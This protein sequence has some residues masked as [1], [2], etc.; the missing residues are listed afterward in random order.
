MRRVVFDRWPRRA[1]GY[2]QWMIAGDV[3]HA[4]ELERS[5]ELEPG[6]PH[7]LEILV[8]GSALIAYVDGSVAMSARIHDRPQGDWGVFVSEGAATFTDLSVRVRRATGDEPPGG[9]S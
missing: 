5:I 6:V 7:R 1:P 3:P 9:G 2:H 8:D 4:V